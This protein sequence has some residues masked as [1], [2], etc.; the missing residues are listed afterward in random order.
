MFIFVIIKLKEKRKSRNRS[1]YIP[2]Y[3]DGKVK[4][5]EVVLDACSHTAVQ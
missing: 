4:L 1:C 5:R 3:R 2:L